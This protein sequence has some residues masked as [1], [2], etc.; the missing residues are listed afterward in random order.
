MPFN[1]RLAR[2]YDPRPLKWT[3]SQSRA[4]A[5]NVSGVIQRALLA[6]GFMAMMIGTYWVLSCT[7]A[8][9]DASVLADWLLV[10]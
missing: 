1:A 4:V 3:A 2:H 8:A 5:E 9:G 6:L 10:C 7:G